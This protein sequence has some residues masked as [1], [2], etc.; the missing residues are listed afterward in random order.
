MIYH[1]LVTGPNS[2]EVVDEMGRHHPAAEILRAGKIAVE[3]EENFPFLDGHHGPL[4]YVRLSRRMI[5]GDV[6]APLSRAQARELAAAAGVK[7]KRYNTSIPEP[8]ETTPEPEESPCSPIE[9][10]V[11]HFGDLP[12]LEDLDEAKVTE[13]YWA[14]RG[15]AQHSIVIRTDGAWADRDVILRT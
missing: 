9:I 14:R 1:R 3:H 15:T 8:R 4:Y 10:T 7:I 12:I 11:N 6:C 13:G 5:G 2:Y